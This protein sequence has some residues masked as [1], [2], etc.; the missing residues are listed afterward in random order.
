MIYLGADH[1]GFKLKEQLKSYLS[2]KKIKY[3]DLGNFEFAPNDDY[4]EIS[5][6]VG[7]AVAK[8]KKATGILICGTGFGVCIAANKVKSIR[9][10]TVR[11][12]AE[13]KSARMHNDAN[14]MCLSGWDLKLDL[15]KKIIKV[16]IATKFS[17]KLR[18]KRRLAKIKKYEGS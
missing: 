6:K 15:A 4:P 10:A 9:A 16:W 13:A 5:F 18:H 7:K 8:D 2:A 17:N 3:I 12:T 11:N 14:L 1:G